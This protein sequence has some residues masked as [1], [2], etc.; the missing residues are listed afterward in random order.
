MNK[1]DLSLGMPF[2]T[3]S[4][5]LLILLTGCGTTQAWREGDHLYIKGNGAKM[6][7]WA[8]GA[9]IERGELLSFQTLQYR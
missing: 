1:V 9:Q 2:K 7:K 6:A 8:D 3:L 4:L 5:V